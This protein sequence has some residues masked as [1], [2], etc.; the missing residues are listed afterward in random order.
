MVYLGIDGSPNVI[1]LRSV[2]RNL[3]ILTELKK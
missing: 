1:F 3:L 2:I